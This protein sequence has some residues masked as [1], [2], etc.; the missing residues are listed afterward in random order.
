MIKDF[1]NFADIYTK[2]ITKRDKTMSLNVLN[3]TFNT[4]VID[5]TVL[6]EVSKELLRRAEAKNSQS[7]NTSA[8]NNVFRPQ[9]IGVDLYNGKIDTNMQRQIA[10]NNSGLN[11]QLN[12]EVLSSIQ[13]LNTKAAQNIQ[14]NVEGK[15]TA[16]LNESQGINGQTAADTKFNSIIS[17]AAGKDKNGS[18]PSYKGELLFVKKDNDKEEVSSNNIFNTIF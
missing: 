9:N 17:M 15:I 8:L 6:N 3:S 18:N 1:T 7:A 2:E 4:S 10:L 5:R 11:I 13:Y 12:S 16:A 14:K